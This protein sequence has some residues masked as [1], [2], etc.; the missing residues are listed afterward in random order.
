M[1][2]SSR[3]VLVLR[4]CHQSDIASGSVQACHTCWGVAFRLRVI[5][6]A[7]AIS[8][9]ITGFLLR[10]V[11]L[12]SIETLVPR[13]TLLFNPS[14]NLIETV[15]CQRTFSPLCPAIAFH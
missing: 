7:L 12:E 13:R 8:V 2:P 5:V 6:K 10:E 1:L 14:G 15:L 4:G 3:G 9:V 11:I